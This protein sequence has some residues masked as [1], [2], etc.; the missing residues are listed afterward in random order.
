MVKR[1]KNQ[2]QM[3]QFFEHWKNF[4]DVV[5]QYRDYLNSALGFQ[6]R[7]KQCEKDGLIEAAKVWHQR[8]EQADQLGQQRLAAAEE[9]FNKIRLL[10]REPEE[11][12][13]CHYL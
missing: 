11:E 1:T 8:V 3:V 5:G 13:Q 4:S 12:S 10:L 2:D 6:A 7:I 9:L